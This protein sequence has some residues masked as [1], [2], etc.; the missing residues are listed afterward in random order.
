MSGCSARPTAIVAHPYWGR[1]GAESAAMW[2]IESLRQDFDVTVYTLGGFDLQEMNALADTAI[3][4]SEVEVR[5]ADEAN[6]WPLGALARGAYL[7]SLQSVGAEYDLRVTASGVAHW[8]LPAIQFISSAIWNESL[9]TKFDAPNAPRHRTEAQAIVWRLAAVLSGQRHRS[10]NDDLFVANSDWTALQSA[11]HCPRSIRIIHPA[12][13]VPPTGP[14]WG[15][16]ENGVLVL[17]RVSPEKNIELCIQIIERLRDSG[18]PLRLCIAGPNGEADYSAHIDSLCRERSEWI[19]RHNLVV[20]HEKRRL[21]GRF[22]YG[23]SA[24]S[25]EAFG[26]A[27]AEMSAAGLITLAPKSGVPTS[28]HK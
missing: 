15:G 18:W 12:V 7:G 19:E 1:G 14:D 22:R 23:L 20:G 3:K 24:C 8:G 26:I 11:P 2:V 17:G 9:A 21:L 13:P 25:I 5:I 27:T 10:L 28:R 4:S 16:R 6:T